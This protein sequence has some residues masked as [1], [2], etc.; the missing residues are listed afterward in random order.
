MSLLE[1]PQMGA[2]CCLPQ[3]NKGKVTCLQRK[4]V[5][6]QQKQYIHI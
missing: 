1:C 3:Y 4:N 6:L 2:F 5:Y